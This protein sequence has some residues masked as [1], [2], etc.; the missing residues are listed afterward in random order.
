M[1][2][3]ALR[4]LESDDPIARIAEAAGYASEPAFHRAFKRAHQASPAAWRR[5][6]AGA[7]GRTRAPVS[8]ADRA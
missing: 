4:L 6:H 2:F 8:P 5:Q 3:A 7:A 1:R